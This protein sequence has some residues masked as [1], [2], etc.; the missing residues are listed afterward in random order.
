MKG[1][2]IRAGTGIQVI[3]FGAD[4]FLFAGLG[5]AKFA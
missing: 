1:L 3:S 5:P 2:I 4:I